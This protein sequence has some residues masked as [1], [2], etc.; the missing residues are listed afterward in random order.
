MSIVLVTLNWKIHFFFSVLITIVCIW[1]TIGTTFCRCCT[2]ICSVR[3]TLWVKSCLTGRTVYRARSFFFMCFFVLRRSGDS[4]VPGAFPVLPFGI[5]FERASFFVFLYLYI[6]T[7][8]LQQNPLLFAFLIYFFIKNGG[9][10]RQ[11]PIECFV[12]CAEI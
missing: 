3:C 6:L 10:L 8:F 11:P 1:L 5:W 7:F 9:L 2:L 4:L 12:L